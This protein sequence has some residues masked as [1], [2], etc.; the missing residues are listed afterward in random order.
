MSYFRVL[1][2]KIMLQLYRWTA[3]LVLYGILLAIVSYV[4]VI[5]FYLC[6]DSWVAPVLISPSNTQILALTETLVTSQQTIDSF[7]IDGAKQITTTQEMVQQKSALEK[8]DG[9]LNQA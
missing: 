3:L 2:S 1:I 8:L 4:G 5:V 6:S 7:T 9:D